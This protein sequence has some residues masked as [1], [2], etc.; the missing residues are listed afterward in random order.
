MENMIF[1]I[2]SNLIMIIIVKCVKSLLENK[3]SK[4][5][6]NIVD[7]QYHGYTFNM[8]VNIRFNI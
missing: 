5:P 4:Q 6:Q 1:Q 2:M 3:K 7:N 8:V